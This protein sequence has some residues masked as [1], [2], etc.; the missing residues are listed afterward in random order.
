MECWGANAEGQLGDGTRTN[1][2]TPVHVLNVSK[3]VEAIAAGYEHTCAVAENRE[4][5]CWGSNQYGQLGNATDR[6]SLSPVAVRGLPTKAEAI[7]CGD[8]HTC[9]LL[10]GGAVMCWGDNRHGQ[11]GHGTDQRTEGAVPV[12]GLTTGVSAISAGDNHTCALLQAGTV[13]CW[14]ENGFGQVGDG[15]TTARLVPVKVVTAER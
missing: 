6:R 14:G 4:V 12:V 3:R 10:R 11:L 7:T 5:F 2:S 15:T 8:A 9:V 1:R 13:E